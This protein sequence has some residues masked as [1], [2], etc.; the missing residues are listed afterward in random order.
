[1]MLKLARFASA[2]LGALN[3]G[4]AWAHLIE[5]RP[6]RA[7]SGPDWV[8]TRQAYRDFGKVARVTMPGALVSTLITLALVRKQRLT[9][10]LT[11]LGAV[12]TAAT[13]AIWARFNE[14]V[15]REIVTW[16]ADALPAD[17]Q[18][19]RRQWELAHAASAGLHAAGVMALLVA[20][21]RD[22][23]ASTK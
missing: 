11:A 9:A 14:P 4:L 8:T 2:L 6:K 13:V 7:M 18:Q 16:Q 22:H 20:A 3:L 21:L 19:R 17:W 12:C 15:N 23:G 5:M 1:M 10:L